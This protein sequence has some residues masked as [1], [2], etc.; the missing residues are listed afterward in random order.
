MHRLQD[1]VRLHRMGEGTRRAARQLRMSPNTARAYRAALAAAGLLDGAPDDLPALEVLRAAIEQHRPPKVAPQESSSIETWS[2][3]V[4][5]MLKAELTAKAI[6]D[7]LR[8]EHGPQF[9]GSYWAVKRMCRRLKRLWGASA[10]EISL[11]VETAPGEVAQVDFGEIGKVY[12]PEQHVLRRAWVFVMVLGFS[13]HMFAKVVFDQKTETWLNLHAEAFHALGGVPKIIVPDN[14]KAA[15]VRAAFGSSDDPSLNRSYREFARHYGFKIDPTPAYAPKK[16]GKVE[17]GVKY[18]KNNALLGRDGEDIDSLNATLTRWVKEIA[19]TRLHGSTGRPPLALF[20]ESERMHLLPLPTKV[21]EPIIWK[22]ARVHQD[23]HLCFADALYSVPWTWVKQQLWVRGTRK[24]VEI[25]GPDEHRVAT[26]PRGKAGSRNTIEAH[27]P[28]GRRDLRHRSRSYWEERAEAL[29]PE[30]A[31][32]V[33]EVFDSDDVLH[34]LRGVQAIVTYLE[35]F[36][37]E[38]ARAACLRA[39]FYG[40]FG[41]RGIK[42]ILTKALDL[43]PLPGALVPPAGGGGDFRFARNLSELMAAKLEVSREPH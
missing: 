37:K 15:V 9:E 14:L 42:S 20:E 43:E 34:Q 36:P 8:L 5:S 38:R 19:G 11:T 33:K 39:S 16:K 32:Y 6:Y 22:K 12:D 18:V 25:Y 35:K 27:L 10:E 30:V 28:E 31:A 21:W 29:G 7:R 26:H 13:R 24:S 2:A 3:A 23:V 17:S 40:N 1:L 41:Y 4:E